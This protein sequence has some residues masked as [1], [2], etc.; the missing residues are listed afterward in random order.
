M[1]VRVFPA[2]R[3]VALLIAAVL[4]GC[5]VGPN[6]HLPVKATFN[7]PGA[8]V[9]FVG[10]SNNLAVKEGAPPS[11]WWH[12][13]RSPDLDRL[14]TAALT[15][16]TDL[17][18]ANAN[19][20][21]SR[22]MVD[23]ERSEGQPRF[24]LDLGYSR[25]QTSA[26]QYLSSAHLTPS[27]ISDVKLSASYEL[28][29]FGR[30]RRGMEAATAG[31]EAVEAARDWVRVS[32]AADVT[33]AY[34]EVCSTGSEL[35]VANR[36]LDL[37]RRSLALTQQLQAGGRANRLDVT[38]VKNLVDQIEASIPTIRARR[39]NA[40]FRLATL[41]GKPP[42]QFERALTRCVVAPS[43]EQPIPVGD[44]AA[45]LGRRPDVRAAERQLAASTAEIGV[46]T[47]DLYP[48]IVLGASIGSA[49]RVDD[50]LS[51]ATNFW[52]V[53]PG[54]SW[55]F[56]QNGPR[57]RIAAATAAQD[58]QLAR[59]DGVVLSALR[60]VESALNNYTH[61]LARQVSLGEARDEAARAVDDALVLQTGGRSG[62]LAT[63]DAERTLIAA[64]AA[65]ASI[66]TQI[67]RDQVVLFLALG[68][69]W[70]ATAQP[71]QNASS[72][73]RRR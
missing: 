15:E 10:A 46:A 48:R 20:E 5:T 53:G 67:S 50:M 26:E 22:A 40:L 63:L 51:H 41:T 21:R 27:D 30:I 54:I 31:S 24:G 14:V 35:A 49:G 71:F 47:A 43:L 33:S 1:N 56:N 17:R 11:Q 66:R 7:A 32:V 38:R 19:L 68:G 25:A 62:A 70:E 16:N 39:R 29:L 73:A 61:D 36:S 23:L 44:G 57:A 69:G 18:V 52:N 72:R 8:Q 3:I 9:P 37:Q 13:Y 42:S 58:G 2:R 28:D 65:L 6:Y 34:L 45:L 55:E 64:E 60:E 59:F 4:A 12:L